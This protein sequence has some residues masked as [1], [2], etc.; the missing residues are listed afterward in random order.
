[1]LSRAAVAGAS[2]TLAALVATASADTGRAHKR[3]QPERPTFAGFQL[4]LATEASI[5]GGVR[6]GVGVRRDRGAL[7]RVAAEATGGAERGP[8]RIELPLAAAHEQLV[9]ANLDET[10]GELGL[11]VRYRNGPRFRVTGG[12]GLR[13]VWRPSWPD[14]YQPQG[15]GVYDTTDRYSFWERRAELGLAAI[16]F[17]H[18]HARVRYRY[19]LLDYATDPAFAPVAAPTHLAPFDKARHEVALSWRYLGEGWKLGATLDLFHESAYFQFARDA[20]TGLTHAPPGGPPP[21]PLQVIRGA[22]PAIEGEVE[23]AHGAVVVSAGYG[24]E[25]VEDPFQGYYSY[26]GHHP[27]LAASAKVGPIK[28][29]VGIEAWLRRYGDGSYQPGAG[30]PPLLWGDRRA[31]RRVAVTAGVAWTIARGLAVT[32][33]SRVLVRRTNLPPYVPET[34]PA[35]REYDIDWSYDNW[36]ALLGLAFVTSAPGR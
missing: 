11:E 22:E 25:L 35:G 15:D 18:Q 10:S 34:Y 7:W 32:F 14:L 26:V 16:P 1:M 19:R 6:D 9:S 20:G 24:L 2:V 13:A 12:A 31:D 3:K 5:A 29:K 33:E 30:H 4:D 21:N 36:Q 27:S 17:R 28:T 8:I 23:L